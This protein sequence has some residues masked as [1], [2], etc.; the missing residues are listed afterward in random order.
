MLQRYAEWSPTLTALIRAADEPVISREIQVTPPGMHWPSHP[1]LTLIGDAAHLMPPVGE[2]AN[3]ALRDA[4]DL[5]AEVIA[6]PGDPAGAIARYE[7]HMRARIRPIERDSSKM[8]KL[9]LSPTA[10]DD[11]VRFFTPAADRR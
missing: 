11:M 7:T 6:D 4:A 2:G 1:S 9:I 8:Q 10:L 3:Q 5:A